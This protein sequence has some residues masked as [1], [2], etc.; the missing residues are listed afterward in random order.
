MA[1]CITDNKLIQ[2]ETVTGTKIQRFYAGANVFITG[3]TGFLGKI[4]IEKLLRS[5]PDINTVYILVRTKKGKNMYE[6]IED[7]FEDPVF[8]K[9]KT[10]CPKF[11]HKVVG[12]SGDVGMPEMGINMQDKQLLKNEV[13]FFLH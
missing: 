13:F 3:S 2:N 5:C 6:R 1:P 9:L 8:E 12:I 4:L 7:M 11:R 10:E